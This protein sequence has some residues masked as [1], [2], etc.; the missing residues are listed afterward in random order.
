[1]SDE[2]P[3]LDMAVLAE[4]RASVA[5]DEAF[6]RELAAAYL[7]EGTD[8]LAAIAAAAG[9]GDAAAIVRPAHTLKSSSAALAAARLAA[10]CRQIEFGGREGRVAS[11]AEVE[12]VRAT[13][14]AT[15]EALKAAGLA[16]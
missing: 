11:A 6:V 12:T 16:E 10:Q 7:A 13:W 8:H 4:L 5:G 1:M 3:I 14:Q 15:I 2:L 9:A